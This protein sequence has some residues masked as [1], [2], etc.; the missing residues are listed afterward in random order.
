MHQVEELARHAGHADI[1][2]EELDGV[3]VPRIVLSLEGAPANEFFEPYVPAAG[4]IGA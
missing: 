1:V 3:S 4:T 2:R